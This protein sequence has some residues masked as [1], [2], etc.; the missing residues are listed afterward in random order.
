MLP[1]DLPAL[2]PLPASLKHR[3]FKVLR[4]ALITALAA[5]TAWYAYRIWYVGQLNRFDHWSNGMA[6]FKADGK[7]GYVNDRFKIVI[8]AQFKTAEPFNDE[9]AIVGSSFG[10]DTHYHLIDKTGRYVSES[11]DE[12]SPLGELRYRARRNLDDKPPTALSNYAWQLLDTNGKVLS[13]RVYQLIDPFRQQRARVCIKLHKTAKVDC[14]FID[15]QGNEVIALGQGSNDSLAQHVFDFSQ[16]P[17]SDIRHDAPH[18]SEDLIPVKRK[19]RNGIERYGYSNRQSQTVIEPQFLQARNFND[20]LAVV[21]TPEGVG[22]INMQGRFIMRPDITIKINDF[23]EQRAIFTQ[24]GYQGVLD[25]TGRV[26]VPVSEQYQSIGNF[27]NDVASTIR[28]SLN[29]FIDRSGRAI[30]PPIYEHLGGEFVDD[31]VW[32]ISPQNPSEM[33]YLNRQNQI[34]KRKHLSVMH[35]TNP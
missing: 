2:V 11:Y 24:G 3:L 26:I 35:S 19:D 14:G 31:T 13:R 23:F 29:G 16:K 34:V 28:N 10:T 8:P 17:Y 20:G 1:E 18:V 21:T 12:I 22:V 15:P 33:L 4:M 5:F 32:A 30:I 27:S 9:R 25:N 6:T 7:Y